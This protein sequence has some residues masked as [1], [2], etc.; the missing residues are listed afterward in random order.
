MQ[1]VVLWGY[2]LAVYWEVLS[3]FEPPESAEPR[4]KL[5]GKPILYELQLPNN[6]SL[7]QTFIEHLNGPY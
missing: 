3:A 4:E 7:S 6:V 2:S 1:L 5:F